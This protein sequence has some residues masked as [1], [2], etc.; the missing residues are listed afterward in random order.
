MTLPALLPELSLM[1]IPMAGDAGRREP[2]VGSATS[3]GRKAPHSAILLH[4]RTMTFAALFQR[5]VLTQKRIARLPMIKGRT[6]S[7]RPTDHPIGAA[8]MFFMARSAVFAPGVIALAPP[9]PPA[10]NTVAIQT[11]TDVDFAFFRVAKAAFGLEGCV[12][13]RELSG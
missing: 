13:L 12:R 10:Q 8:A 9:H 11:A 2:K 5:A 3:F 1:R 7:G 4:R 6:P